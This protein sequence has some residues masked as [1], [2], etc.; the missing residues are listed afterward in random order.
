MPGICLSRSGSTA[1][2][3][4]SFCGTSDFFFGETWASLYVTPT[5]LSTDFL[6]PDVEVWLLPEKVITWETGDG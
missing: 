5:S 1:S 2:N 3:F 4:C 6:V